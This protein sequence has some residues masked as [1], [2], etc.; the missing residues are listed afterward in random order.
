MVLDE[1]TSKVETNFKIQPETTIHL[2]ISSSDLVGALSLA[3]M[4]VLVAET[5][6]ESRK[7]V[8]IVMTH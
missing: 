4:H 8:I 7:E 5:V 2:E 6:S 3:Y 1:G